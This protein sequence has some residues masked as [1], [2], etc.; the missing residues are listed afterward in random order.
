MVHQAHSQITDENPAVSGR[1]GI[2]F[3]RIFGWEPVSQ[4]SL[5]PEERKRFDVGTHQKKLY[6][7]IYIDRFNDIYIYICIM[8]Y[9]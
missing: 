8:I 6:I 3:D 4:S 1:N 7:Y 9:T 2:V 5:Q